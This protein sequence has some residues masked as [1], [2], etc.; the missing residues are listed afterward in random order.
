MLWRLFQASLD[1]DD[2]V[3]AK[4]WC[5]EGQ[6]RF[7]AEPRFVE[8]QLSLLSLRGQR[9]D[10]RSAWA[11]LDQNIQLY[12]PGD[13]DYRRRRGQFLVA[14]ALAR[15]GLADSAR[16]VAVRARADATVDPAREFLYL[17]AILRAM[18]GDRD[19]ALRLLTTYLATNPQERAA[20]AKDDTWWWSG[21][22]GDPRFKKLVGL[23]S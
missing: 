4:R 20:L 14:M 17:E 15:A 19:E 1:L 2:G 18:L 6:R 10:G 23:A 22:R 8:C 13:R 21:L 11:L 9:P 5:Q 16:A 3:E 7:P 12:P